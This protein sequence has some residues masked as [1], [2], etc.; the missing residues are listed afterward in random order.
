M[1]LT[2][3]KKEIY[4]RL[5]TRK[6][7][8]KRA[9]NTP[10][11]LDDMTSDLTHLPPQHYDVVLSL[12]GAT[13]AKNPPNFI[14]KAGRLL[15]P[16]GLLLTAMLG[17]ESFK[18]LR[19]IAP[20]KVASSFMALPDVP[21]VGDMLHRLKFALPVIDRDV[22]TLTFSS[23]KA[24]QKA[25]VAE[26]FDSLIGGAE[27]LNTAPILARDD[28]LLAITLEVIYTAGWFPHSSQPT[29]LPV[30]SVAVPLA[31]VL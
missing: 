23:Q 27:W 30:G 4:Q 6:S 9:F 8:V 3:I 16:D 11:F 29:A 22:I 10:L 13:F 17:A 2:P 12:L 31:K 26:G 18:E 28:G 14:L 20:K 1:P 25:L 24:L 19:A 21:T 15:Q 5:L 7:D